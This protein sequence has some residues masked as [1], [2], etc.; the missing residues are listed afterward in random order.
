MKK[1]LTMFFF[2]MM[3]QG[4]DGWFCTES[5]SKI[6]HS[7]IFVCGIG[8]SRTEAEARNVS[9]ENAKIEFKNICEM[10]DNCKDH[11]TSVMPQ[12]MSCVKSEEG[13]KCFRM[14]VFEIGPIVKKEVTAPVKEKLAKSLYIGQD[15]KEVLAQFGRPYKADDGYDF[16][17]GFKIYYYKGAMC[18]STIYSC[19]IRIKNEKVESYDDIKMEFLSSADL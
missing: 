5:A 8:E 2:P 1:L 14:V 10:S 19:W 11:E 9:F 4:A 12:R 15:K 16:D 7:N 18:R 3:S 13:Y 17:N 6:Q